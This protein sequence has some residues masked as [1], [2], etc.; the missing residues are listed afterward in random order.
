MLDNYETDPL[1]PEEN[2]A[3]A[4]RVRAG[5]QQ[6]REDLILGNIPLVK[7]R[8]KKWIGLY[9]HLTYLY[10][11]MVSEGVLGL[12]KAV[13]IMTRTDTRNTTGF[14]SVGIAKTIGNFVAAEENEPKISLPEWVSKTLEETDTTHFIDFVD[15][16]FGACDTEEHRVILKMRAEGASEAGIAKVL[17]CS[18]QT[19]SVLL[20]DIRQN[21]EESEE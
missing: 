1:T 20:D 4:V 6:A 18:Q 14:L 3:L 16:L 11:D 15:S 17:G 19:I 12:V 7:Y 2:D 8:V 9:P 13:E 10:E 5:D 21:F